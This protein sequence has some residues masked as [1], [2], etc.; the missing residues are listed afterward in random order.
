MKYFILITALLAIA[1]CSPKRDNMSP[2]HTPDSQIFSI[3]SQHVKDSF[4]ISLKLPPGYDQRQHYPVVYVLD[5][6]FYFDMVAATTNKYAELGILTP[7]IIVGIGYKNF[8]TMD[9]LRDRDYS[10]PQA[11]AKD[12][13]LVSGGASRFLAFIHS[14]LIPV[15]DK[16]YGTDPKNRILM[17]HSL[18]GYFTLFAFQKYLEGANNDFCSY[19]AASPSVHYASYYLLHQLDSLATKNASAKVKLYV[20]Y[21]GLEDKEDEGEPGILKTGEIANALQTSIAKKQAS[22][23][24]YKYDTYSAFG[25]MDM[26]IPSFTK[27]LAWILGQ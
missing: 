9:S 13:F 2:A 22:C 23:V 7:A 1:A 15:I 12:S 26:G 18:G 20:T 6:N 3:Y 25:H 17:G 5:A 19:V 11:L 14:E 27:G 4:Y 21:G 8:A 10:Y 16:Q 24:D